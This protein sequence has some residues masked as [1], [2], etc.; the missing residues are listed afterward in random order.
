MNGYG[1]PSHGINKNNTFLVLAS[2]HFLHQTIEDF[3]NLQA[4]TLH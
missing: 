4:L 2:V 1:N 3:L